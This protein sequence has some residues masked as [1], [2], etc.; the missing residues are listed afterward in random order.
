MRR[1]EAGDLIA[2]LVRA[3][4]LGNAN[5]VQLLL[6]H[7]ADT[8]VGYHCNSNTGLLP[9]ITRRH[10]SWNRDEEAMAVPRKVN[11]A[12]GRVIQLATELGHDEIVELLVGSG[13]D[14]RLPQP[15]WAGQGHTCPVV[16]R[17]VWLDVTIGLQERMVS[18]KTKA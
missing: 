7:G 6:A 13:T 2:P 1:L 14:D 5:L 3:V 16:P 9:L 17:T 15:V 12:C 4:R 11:F 8:N 18:A 10:Q